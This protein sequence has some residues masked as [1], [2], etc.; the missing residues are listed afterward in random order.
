MALLTFCGAALKEHVEEVLPPMLIE[1]AEEGE[2][3]VHNCFHL[4]LEAIVIPS[5]LLE[6]ND[7]FPVGQDGIGNPSEPCWPKGERAI[8]QRIL[9]E[10]EYLTPDSGYA[11]VH[12]GDHFN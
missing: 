8:L 12:L 11:Q 9:D 2:A 5:G 3:F 6:K 4:T 7:W 1:E 10:G